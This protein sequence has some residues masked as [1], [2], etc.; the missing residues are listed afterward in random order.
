MVTLH[1]QSDNTP[2]TQAGIQCAV[3]HVHILY[4]R[5]I[6]DPTGGGSVKSNTLAA[7][8]VTDVRKVYATRLW[9]SFERSG[10]SVTS[11]GRMAETTLDLARDTWVFRFVCDITHPQSHIS[12][13]IAQKCMFTSR[14]ALTSGYCTSSKIYH[15]NT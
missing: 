5:D 14:S 3:L 6:P 7:K 4:A 8:Y 12:H 2:G 11:I 1:L 15:L 10:T 9:L 13:A